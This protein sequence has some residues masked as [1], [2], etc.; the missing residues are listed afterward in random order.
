MAG[1]YKSKEVY[2]QHR[3]ALVNEPH[4]IP[5]RGLYVSG[6]HTEP[7]YQDHDVTITNID[8][9]PIQ[10]VDLIE[11]TANR[12]IGQSLNLIDFYTFGTIHSVTYSKAS[13]DRHIGQSLNL[14]DFYTFGN[15]TVE[16]YT[17][18]TADRHIGQSL[19]LIDFYTFGN[20]TYANQVN[21]Y[22]TSSEP[23]LTLIACDSGN[24]NI[25]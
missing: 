17:S 9:S 10:Y 13:A 2:K 3:D 11:T 24:L 18:T 14:I 12:H 25:E 1:Y 4:I 6:T 5:V 15:L 8:S 21:L 23:S 19:N 22:Q 16:S 7:V 20:L